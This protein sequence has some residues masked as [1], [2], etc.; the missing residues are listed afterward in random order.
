MRG[1]GLSRMIAHTSQKNQSAAR[2]RHHVDEPALACGG[3]AVRL[4]RGA[5]L[6]GAAAD[7]DPA[8]GRPAV[9]CSGQVALQM[10]DGR[11]G[12]F[13]H[14]VYECGG[15]TPRLAGAGSRGPGTFGSLSL[16]RVVVT[17]AS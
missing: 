3:R 10:I 11:P 9:C 8:V 13:P 1:P 17:P 5:C 4:T 2:H 14:P 6:A 15:T 16:R 7:D 12:R